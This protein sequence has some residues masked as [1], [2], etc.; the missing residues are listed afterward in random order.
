LIQKH[1]SEETT[2]KNLQNL[3]ATIALCLV[4]GAPVCAGDMSSPPVPA[5][6]VAPSNTSAR[7]TASK[8][9]NA[10]ATVAGMDAAT[11]AIDL[12]VSMLSIY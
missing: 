3:V 12:L 9:K 4:L 6:P 1:P 2:M 8:S 10:N 7:A 5:P 11:I